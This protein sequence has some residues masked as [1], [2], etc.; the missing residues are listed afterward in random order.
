[1]AYTP[2]T[3]NTGDTITASALN[4]M[5]QGIVEGGGG[6]DLV[7]TCGMSPDEVT[8]ISNFSITSGS[9]G[10]L[11]QSLADGN[12][13]KA[14]CIFMYAYGGSID[15]QLIYEMVV[16]DISYSY[17]RFNCMGAGSSD[18]RNLDISFNSSYTMT[19]YSFFEA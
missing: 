17:I 15:T 5:E 13:V 2:T 14:A 11:V 8:S 10:G 6:Y 1:M 16:A 7:I 12:I 3:W 4:K 19:N 18:R 9:I